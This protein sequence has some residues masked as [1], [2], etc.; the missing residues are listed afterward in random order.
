[1]SLIEKVEEQVDQKRALEMQ[2]K[3]LDNDFTLEDFR[4]Q[5]K[6]I[7]RLGPL[8]SVLGLLPQVG[9]LQGLQNVDVDPKEMVRTEAIINSMTFKE[10]LNHG[11]LNG[12]RRRRIAEGS[13]TS[14]QQV[15]QLLRQYRQMRHMMRSISG[16]GKKAKRSLAQMGMKTSMR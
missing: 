14:V 6:Q 10:R 7:K 5:L 1:M 11:V 2:Q 15:N 13:G 16:G 3:V 8:E 9:P 12:R 4:Q